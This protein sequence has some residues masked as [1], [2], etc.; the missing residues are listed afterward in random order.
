MSEENSHS[1]IKFLLGLFIGGIIGAVIIFFL[2]TKEG[3]KTGKLLEEKGKDI[4]DDISE[5]VSELEEKG[6][7]LIE[8]TEVIKENVVAEVE[9]KKEELTQATSEKLDTALA[10]IEKIQ[11]ESAQTTA[12]LRKR[13]FKNIPKKR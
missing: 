12:E 1:D 3:K 8:Q 4:V 6:K 13:L 2:G 5:K 10:H 11:T 9:E 7:E